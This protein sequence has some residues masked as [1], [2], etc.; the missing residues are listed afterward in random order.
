MALDIGLWVMYFVSI[1]FAVFWLSIIFENGVRD[2]VVKKKNRKFPSVTITIPVFNEEKSVVGTIESV[3]GLDYPS[4]KLQ[5]IVVDDCSTDN[6][7]LAVKNYM[8]NTDLKNVD[9]KYICHEVNKG[10]GAALNT[11]LKISTGELFICLDADSFVDSTVLKEVVPHFDNVNVASVL[12]L[13]KLQKVKGFTLGLQYVEY[14]VNFFMKKVMSILDC[15]HV[16]PGPFAS[17]RKKVLVDIGGFDE[18]NLTED[19]EIALRLQKGNHK[20]IQL[21]GPKVYTLGPETLKGWFNQRNRWYKGTLFNMR[22]YRKLFFNKDYGEFGVFHLPMVLGAALLSIFFSFFVIWKHM[23]SPL[24]SKLYD[25]SFI[26]FDVGLMTSVWAERFSFL[27]INYGLIFFTFVV[28][29]F[30]L[31]W[32]LY[33]FKYTE[34]SFSSQGFFSASLFMVIYPFFLSL[35]WLGVVF[36]LARNKKQKW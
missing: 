33:A 15:V 31:A 10:K 7:A 18:D 19:Q 3:L 1:Y 4:N 23:I 2:P 20:I 30:G 6:T 16:T 5:V 21:I 13:M 25:M 12:P 27:D 32:I 17:Y 9:F 36:D 11:A 24:L 26:S 8:K 28:M 14:L 29:S 34:E 22:D 35:V